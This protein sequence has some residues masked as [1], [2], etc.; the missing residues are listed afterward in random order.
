MGIH[1]L[2]VVLPTAYLPSWRVILF[3]MLRQIIK[4]GKTAHTT[5]MERG[6]RAALQSSRRCA[7]TAGRPV[8]RGIFKGT[9]EAQNLYPYPQF[10][11]VKAAGPVAQARVFEAAGETAESL[12][13]LASDYYHSCVCSA[14]ELAGS[15]AQKAE[16]LAQLNAGQRGA[17][18]VAEEGYVRSR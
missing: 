10:R 17:Y 18:C 3:L 7:S 12:S 16:Q 15:D 9:L 14:L 2:R 5:T 1:T 8:L 11:D 13:G 4:T 6:V